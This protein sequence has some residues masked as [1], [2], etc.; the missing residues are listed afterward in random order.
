[1][2]EYRTEARVCFLFRPT[3]FL[4]AV[5]PDLNQGQ[6]NALV[7]IGKRKVKAEVPCV[8]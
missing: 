7:K 2:F 4:P 3:L 6:G 1:M 8:N 5:V